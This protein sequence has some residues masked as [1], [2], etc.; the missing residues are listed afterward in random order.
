V[1]SLDN[2]IRDGEIRMRK[3]ITAIVAL[4]TTLGVG[5]WY[6]FPELRAKSLSLPQDLHSVRDHFGVTASDRRC[7][8]GTFSSSFSSYDLGFG[9]KLLIGYG[10][11]DLANGEVMQEVNS[12]EI[13]YE[14]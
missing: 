5:C 2:D 9:R 1:A 11:K 13:M 3:N 10:A 4:I 14:F 7:D 6:F 12:V 8:G